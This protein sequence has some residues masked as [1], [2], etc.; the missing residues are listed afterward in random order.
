ML[1]TDQTVQV[2]GMEWYLTRIFQSAHDHA[3]N[4]E[5]QDVVACLHVRGW[6]K[7]FVIRSC[8][9]PTQGGE[10]PQARG[11]PCIQH[12]LVLMNIALSAHRALSRI[13]AG[14]GHMVIWTIP[15][16]N[17]VTPP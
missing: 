5:E 14:D 1:V 7:I 6:I 9:R 2:D 17:S 10:R 16:R 4:P 8:I 12:I 3:R 13:L 11:E 15:E